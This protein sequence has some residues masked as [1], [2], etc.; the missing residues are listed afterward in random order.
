MTEKNK[1]VLYISQD[2]QN[3]EVFCPGSRECLRSINGNEGYINIQNVDAMLERG[4][5]LPPWLNGTPILVDVESKRALKGTDAVKGIVELITTINAPNPELSPD[6][7]DD[8]GPQGILPDGERYL[9]QE[10]PNQDVINE[11]PQQTREGKVTE[12]DL[13]AYMAQRN[14]SMPSQ[15]S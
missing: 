13:Q 3:S 11:R 8:E 4:I 14:A 10:T 15:S 2:K 7:E 6:L 5:E 1:W 9:H 12:E